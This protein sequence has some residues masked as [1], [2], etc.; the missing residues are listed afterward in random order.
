MAASRWTRV[1]TLNG[2]DWLALA[3]ASCTLAYTHAALR[4]GSPARVIAR[5]TKDA[6]AR[7]AAF[8][9]ARQKRLEW[10]VGVAGRHVVR[11][12]CLTRAIALARILGRRGVR[13]DVRLGVRQIDGRLD[14]H[15]WVELDGRALND[16]ETHV[17]QYAPLE[18]SPATLADVTPW[19]R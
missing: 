4:L 12:P 18:S 3:E 10:L 16:D 15:A 19:I 2:R 7:D 11:V 6:S 13:T 1:W 14:A 8:T 17:R 9:I 5:A